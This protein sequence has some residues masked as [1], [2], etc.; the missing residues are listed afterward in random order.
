MGE[1]VILVRAD[2]RVVALDDGI[3]RGRTA[4]RLTRELASLRDPAVAS[5]VEQT[6]VL[7]TEEGEDPE[8]VGGPPVVLVAVDDDRVRAI[9]ALAAQQLGEALAVDVVAHHG[10]V[11]LGVPVDLHRSRDVAGL[12]EQDVFIGL[13]DHQTRRSQPFREPLRG[14]EAARFG[15]LGELGE[16][17]SN[18]MAMG[19][20]KR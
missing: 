8:G 9:D 13:D 5:A 12:V 17:E 6:H 11:E 15:I 19:S 2:E 1:N 18:S 7:V 4:G 20:P 3:L 10:V 16:E 14:H